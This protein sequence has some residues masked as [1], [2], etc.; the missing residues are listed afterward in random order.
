MLST[1]DG[2]LIR[3]HVSDR[4][5]ISAFFIFAQRTVSE[6]KSLLLS[7]HADAITFGSRLVPARKKELP[8]AVQPLVGD[9]KAFQYTGGGKW[10]PSAL[11]P[12]DRQVSIDGDVWTV[13][14]TASNSAVISNDK[15]DRGRALNFAGD[16][17]GAKTIVGLP[18]PRMRTN[19]DSAY[20]PDTTYLSTLTDFTQRFAIDAIAEG[21]D[22]FYQS[23]EMP[24]TD[25][26]AWRPTRELYSA[27]NRALAQVLKGAL[28]L[29]SPYIA[30]ERDASHATPQ[31]AARGASIVLETA[32][33]TRLL[34]APQDG[35]GTGSA[36][37]L[38]D[39]SRSHIAPLESYLYL[40][41]QAIG[42][43]LWINVELMRP[44]SGVSSR[45]ATTL[46]RVHKQ[47]AAEMPFVTGAIAFIWDD[48]IRRIGAVQILDGAQGLGRGF[49]TTGR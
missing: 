35:L 17:L 37:L 28:V 27:Q 26:P 23:V 1:E 11:A 32:N 39:A 2:F 43:H 4:E 30:S 10:D 21:A 40:I 48:R 44:G 47:L 18:A 46:Q 8:E 14:Y 42:N 34:I 29:V 12:M 38:R 49:G 13:M 31:Q 15:E 45:E 19:G 24:L 6:N 36:A 5:R 9:R 41:R 20:L 25:T 22:G 3:P 33:G 7:M 16:E